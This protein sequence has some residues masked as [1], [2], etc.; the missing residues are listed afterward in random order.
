MGDMSSL[1]ATTPATSVVTPIHTQS[2]APLSHV[3]RIWMDNNTSAFDGNELRLW[4][5]NGGGFEISHMF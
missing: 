3:D 5:A 1:P 2:I 4:K